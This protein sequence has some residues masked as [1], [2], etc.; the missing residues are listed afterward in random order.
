MLNEQ[1]VR[2]ARER[3]RFAAGVAAARTDAARRTDR[4]HRYRKSAVAG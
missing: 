3:A 4:R 1:H 2:A